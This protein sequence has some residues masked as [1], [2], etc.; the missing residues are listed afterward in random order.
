MTTARLHSSRLKRKGML[1][2]PSVGVKLDLAL[3]SSDTARNCLLL[4]RHPAYCSKVVPEASL[5]A[6][7]VVKRRADFRSFL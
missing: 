2:M 4:D 7:S 3:L 6:T 5:F 1:K